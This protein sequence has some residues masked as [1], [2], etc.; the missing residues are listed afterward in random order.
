MDNE[1]PGEGSFPSS[2]MMESVESGSYSLSPAS[3][4]APLLRKF[5]S[6]SSA[7]L[8]PFGP[9]L[10]SRAHKSLS[11]IPVPKPLFWHMHLHVASSSNSAL[12]YRLT[13]LALA[14]VLTSSTKERTWKLS[15]TGNW[16][17]KSRLS[18]G[19]MRGRRGDNPEGG[20]S[21]MSCVRR[22]RRC[23]GERRE[24]WCRI[25]ATTR[26]GSTVSSS[27]GPWELDPSIIPPSSKADR[28][29][30]AIILEEGD[31]S[32]LSF[33]LSV[34]TLPLPGNRT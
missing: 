16:R 9:D 17:R 18:R 31:H 25:W 20:E 7:R 14:K 27:R 12:Q 8:L 33:P 11:S 32:S 19:V 24:N 6:N 13:P 15:S 23:E 21:E 4:P 10:D 29:R 2:A 26:R 22:R 30:F 28:D 1:L 5:S 3:I 34:P